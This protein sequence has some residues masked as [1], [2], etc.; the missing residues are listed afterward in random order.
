MAK[1]VTAVHKGLLLTMLLVGTLVAGCDK[2][3]APDPAAGATPRVITITPS[4]PGASTP[5][6]SPPAD[7]AT[8]AGQASGLPHSEGSIPG[9]VADS[10]VQAWAK[11]WSATPS[12][13]TRLGSHST[14]LTVDFAGGHSNLFMTVSRQSAD[15][16]AASGF[17]CE[18][19]D[20]SHGPWGSV[21]MTRKTV[22]QLVAGCPGPALRAG[23]TKQVVDFAVKY[24]K[25][26]TSCNA[27]GTSGNCRSSDHRINL[28]RF[29][30]VVA[31]APTKFRLYVLGRKGNA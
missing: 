26:D 12:P 13:Y 5:A 30:L 29:Q 18:V 10:V 21:A 19:T 2:P 15:S 6:G 20:N 1:R 9:T 24:A 14:Q 7:I 28:E 11:Q 4:P 25:P 22:E 31:N 3:S 8:L 27:P 16:S 23:E 17:F